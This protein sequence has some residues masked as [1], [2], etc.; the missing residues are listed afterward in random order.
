MRSLPLKA[1]S[2]DM[3][4][5]QKTPGGQICTVPRPKTLQRETKKETQKGRR[6]KRHRVWLEYTNA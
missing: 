5:A 1:K 4:T 6:L 3:S 2:F